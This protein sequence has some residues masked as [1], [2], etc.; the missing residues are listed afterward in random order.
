MGRMGLPQEKVWICGNDSCGHVIHEDDRNKIAETSEG[1]IICPECGETIVREKSISVAA[2]P[3]K[4]ANYVAMLADAFAYPLK[5]AGSLV[6]G[7]ATVLVGSS[8]MIG[9]C[10]FWA[11]PVVWF[12][13]VG[14]VMAYMFEVIDATAV[15]KEEPPDMPGL[16]DDFWET[17]ARSA[18]LFLGVA[19]ISAVP[20]II[21]WIVL[22]TWET[23][24]WPETLG[25]WRTVAWGLAGIV[26]FPMA[27]LAVAIQGRFG[28]AN[29]TIVV[30]SMLRVWG[31][32][33]VVC[34]FLAAAVGVLVAGGIYASTHFH[35]VL[36]YL[37]IHL[38]ALYMIMVDMRLLGLLYR[39]YQ[40]K[41]DW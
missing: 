32:Y 23:I 29:P 22:E 4:P 40:H 16:E 11:A 31:P 20:M 2:P 10:L 12:P 25:I 7:I 35:P 24:G 30:S 5:G 27:L 13:M 26:Y 9:A 33:T 18:L 38:L 8:V 37:A 19:F 3:T 36:T 15:G 34:A 21:S 39:F 6:L 14:Y 1:N 28:A 41:L 17:V